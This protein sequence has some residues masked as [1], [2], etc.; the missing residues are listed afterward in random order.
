MGIVLGTKW[1]TGPASFLSFEEP[2]RDGNQKVLD[3]GGAIQYNFHVV[4]VDFHSCNRSGRVL[5]V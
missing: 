2:H 3:I 5:S 4:F 1:A